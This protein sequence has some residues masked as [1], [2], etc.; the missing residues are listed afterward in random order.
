[1]KNVMVLGKGD[2]AIKIADWFYSSRE[3]NLTHIVPV[4][5]EPTWTDSI[6]KWAKD[7]N[8][9]FTASGH[10]K[11]IEGINDK[12][13]NINL[14]FSVF[15]DKIIKESFILKC[16]R[17][18]NLHNSP[19][20]KYR[21]VR[22]INWALK[23]NEGVHGVT[24][25]EISKGIDD[26]PIVSQLTYSIFPEFDE[27]VDVHKR[28]RRYGWSL[29]KETMLILDKIVATPQDESNATYYSKDKIHLLGERMGNTRQEKTKAISL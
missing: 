11:D 12:N 23:N 1:M 19:L 27:V 20:P 21:G 15:Y 14:T 3:Y 13:W 24:I 26:G 9:P 7:R 28:A 18:L 17:I 6:I 4:V 22:P 10:Y 2:L 8:I 5:P 25:H 29:F 16:G